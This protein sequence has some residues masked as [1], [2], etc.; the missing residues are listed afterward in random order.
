[1]K[2]RTN[3]ELSRFVGQALRSAINQGAWF[4]V[5]YIRAQRKMMLTDGT[6]SLRAYVQGWKIA[7]W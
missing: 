1:M 7:K 3:A 2:T 5:G 6:L 4:M